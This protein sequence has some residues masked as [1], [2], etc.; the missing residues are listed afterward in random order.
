V[1]TSLVSTAIQAI[2]GRYWLNY[3]IVTVLHMMIEEN[4]INAL[5]VSWRSVL[6]GPFY[7]W[8]KPEFPEKNTDL[9]QVTDKLYHIEITLVLLPIKNSQATNPHMTALLIKN[10]HPYNNNYSLIPNMMLKTY[11]VSNINI[12]RQIHTWLL[13]KIKC[14]HDCSWKKSTLSIIR[15]RYSRFAFCLSKSPECLMPLFEWLKIKLKSYFHGK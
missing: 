14:A 3:M 12:Y 1:H 6:F 9:L 5:L 7:W 8:R 2:F 11:S 10:M 15:P 4:H 13:M